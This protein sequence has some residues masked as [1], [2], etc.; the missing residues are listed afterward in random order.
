MELLFPS[1]VQAFLSLQIPHIKQWGTMSNFQITPSLCFLNLPGQQA[2][3]STTSLGKTQ[4]TPKNRKH[5]TPQLTSYRAMQEKMVRRLPC[6][7]TQTTPIHNK[8]MLPQIIISQN[9]TQHHC[10]YKKKLIL[11]GT[12][13]SMEKEYEKGICKAL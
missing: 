6:P 1:K 2:S 13:S 9:S 5:H 10:P 3:K 12:Q 11:E 4:K 7:L 8:P